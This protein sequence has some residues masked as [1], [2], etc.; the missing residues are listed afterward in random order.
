MFSLRLLIAF[1]LL[2]NLTTMGCY[3]IVRTAMNLPPYT[4]A[5]G[6][7]KLE[8]V[9]MRDGV[10]LHTEVFLPDGPGPWPVLLIRNPYNFPGGF[11]PLAKFFTRYGYATVSQLTRG[12]ADSEGQWRPFFD[13]RNDGLDTIQWILEQPWQN[14]RIGLFG[15]S[16]LSM[17]QW[18][19]ADAL[20]PQV[21]TMVPMVWANDLRGVAYRDGMFRP[22]VVTAWA[23]LMHDETLDSLNALN[24]H[25]AIA[26]RPHR[27]VDSLYF[28]A[29]LPW[30]QE[31]IA[32]P[33][34]N[35]PIWQL[36]D[37]RLLAD[38][39]NRVKVPVLSIGA[40]YDIFADGQADEYAMYAQ[41]TGSRLVMGPWTHLVGMGGDGMDFPSATSRRLFLRIINWLDHH[42]KDA[43]LDDWGPVETYVIGAD[44]WRRDRAWPPETQMQ[45]LYFRHADRANGC[46]GGLLLPQPPAEEE[47]ASYIYDPSNPVPSRGGAG[48]L[49]FAIPGWFGTAPSIRDQTGL[50]ERNDVLTFTSFP[51]K[52]DSI[53]AGR[54]SVEL[55]VA[56]DADDTA[57]TAKVMDVDPAGR[58]VNISDSI[59]TLAYRNGATIPVVYE[60]GHRVPIRITMTPIEWMVRKGHRLRVDLSSSN[61]PAYHAHP[62]YAGLWSEQVR[63]RPA[64]QTIYFS[65]E[66]RSV[67]RVPV[68]RSFVPANL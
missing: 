8:W 65:P 16:Y 52:H 60:P 20:P 2:I 33:S 21:K 66:G 57:F 37:A 12:R 61:Y 35:A 50:C 46:T 43:P 45:R 32:S 44:V 41:R 29:V 39:P 1:F 7:T 62:N 55:E 68:L 34:A 59:T 42:L 38:M 48:L 4:H 19:I 6:Q 67:L 10:R 40:W 13:E 11:G 18:A 54:M 14:G 30:Y 5:V 63:W 23:A 51:L 22:E 15:A 49:A 26:H 47:S 9:P 25:R 53:L 17:V 3:S 24:F 56:S 31:W 58:A 27:E 64:R 36:S 28:G